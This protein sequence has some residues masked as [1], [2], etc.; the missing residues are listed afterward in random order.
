MAPGHVV[1]TDDVRAADE[2]IGAERRSTTDDG[3]VVERPE[4]H[5]V[6]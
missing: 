1:T 3:T 4:S 2:P 6:H 5:H